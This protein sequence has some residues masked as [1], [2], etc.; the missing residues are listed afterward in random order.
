[1]TKTSNV[2][3]HKFG[4]AWPHLKYY[5]LTANLFSKQNFVCGVVIASKWLETAAM[6]SSVLNN[7]I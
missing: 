2:D 1:M 4:W 3:M 5:T 7:R 6:E